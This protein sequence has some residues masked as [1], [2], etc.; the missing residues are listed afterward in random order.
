MYF[1]GNTHMSTLQKTYNL[2]LSPLLIVQLNLS[3][4][5]ETERLPAGR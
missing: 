2:P 4:Q 3:K 1:A 5:D